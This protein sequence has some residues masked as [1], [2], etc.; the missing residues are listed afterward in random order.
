MG[1]RSRSTAGDPQFGLSIAATVVTLTI[2]AAAMVAEILVRTAAIVYTRDGTNP[3]ATQG[4]PAEPGDIILLNSRDEL[5]GFRAIRRNATSATVDVE[6]FTDVGGLPAIIRGA[7]V[8]NIAHDDVDVGPPIKVGGLGQDTS[9]TPV[10]ALDRVNAHFSTRGALRV[11]VSDMDTAN[12]TAIN[13]YSGDAQSQNEYGLNVNAHLEA[14]APD[15]AIDRLRTLRDT[16]PGLGVLAAAPYTPGASDVLSI[17][18]DVAAVSASRQTLL[19]PTAGKKVRM[20]S[21]EVV[22]RGLTTNPDRV[23]VYFGTGAAYITTVANAIAEFVPG[24]T[25]E[26]SIQWPDGGGPVGAADAVVSGITE[27]ETELL[28]RYTFQYREE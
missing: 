18:V 27:T 12:I 14:I 17:V 23:G 4:T 6:Y 26:Q 8:G 2:P 13:V 22:T 15:A 24:T 16:A 21:L 5:D 9:P 10:A 11:F 20:I 1:V 19:T 7:L 28:L 25:G 3:T